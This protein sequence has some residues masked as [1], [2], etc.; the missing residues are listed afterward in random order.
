MAPAGPQSSRS[1]PARG[2]LLGGRAGLQPRRYQ[3]GWV[4]EWET[5]SAGNVRS[6]G[7]A[8]RLPFCC[9]S[10]IMH[11]F[12]HIVLCPFIAPFLP[13]C[14]ILLK[15]LSLPCVSTPLLMSPSIPLTRSRS[16]SMATEC[17]SCRVAFSCCLHIS[18]L[19]LPYKVLLINRHHTPVSP[20]HASCPLRKSRSRF[21]S[22][23]LRPCVFVAPRSPLLLRQS[24]SVPNASSVFPLGV[25]FVCVFM[26]LSFPPC[27]LSHTRY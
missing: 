25:F 23:F 19:L 13:L 9:P 26:S 17:H 10:S 24:L 3:Q 7:A 5:W 15:S 6:G 18:L 22:V 1:A 2:G 4:L 11:F 27:H 16:S 14:C 21:P 12:S 8:P 20:S